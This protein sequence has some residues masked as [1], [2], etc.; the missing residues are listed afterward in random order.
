VIRT[1]SLAAA[2][3]VAAACGGSPAAPAGAVARAAALARAPLGD[4]PAYPASR[5]RAEARV[6]AAAVP[7]PPGGNFNGVRWELAGGELPAATI[8]AVLEFNAAC[9]WVRRWSEPGGRAQAAR[10]LRSVP[11]WPAFRGTALGATFARVASE[12]ARGG[13][14]AVEAALAGCRA[15]HARE[16]AYAGE[17][18][19]A[20]SS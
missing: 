18:G 2:A 10:V 12:A 8:D 4:G 16:V 19:L 14:A 17:R 11:A 15:S 13:G 3:L 1:V 6:R 5:A 7:L 20:P 9:Q